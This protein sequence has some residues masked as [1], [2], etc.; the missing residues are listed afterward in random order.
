MQQPEGSNSNG[1]LLV[2]L[3]GPILV[4]AVV[5]SVLISLAQTLTWVAIIQSSL[6]F[7]G[8]AVAC[9]DSASIGHDRFRRFVRTQLE[10][11]VWDDVLHK[12]FHPDFSWYN[13]FTKTF[14]GQAA[15]VYLFPSTPEQRR[16]LLQATL[17]IND[18]DQ[19]QQI[20]FAPGGYQK[21]LLPDSFLQWLEGGEKKHNTG[22]MEREG[23]IKSK[24]ECANIIVV[25]TVLEG[26]TMSSSTSESVSELDTSDGTAHPKNPSPL[27]TEKLVRENGGTN[28]NSSE[29]STQHQQRQR[30]PKDASAYI[31][32]SIAETMQSVI[33]EAVS[34]QIRKLLVYT[35]N[36]KQTAALGV[37]AAVSLAMQLRWSKRS[38]T[39]ALGFLEASSI[40]GLSAVT[41]G[42]GSMFLAKGAFA[43]G[44]FQL[45]ERNLV[46]YISTILN[47]RNN[48][49]EVSGSSTDVG[50]ESNTSKSRRDWRK[51]YYAA[52]VVMLLIGLKK[53]KQARQQQVR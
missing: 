46:S 2:L 32:P 52:A 3:R 4:A 50:S 23:S 10:G 16:H 13:F 28:K 41:A 21:M 18:E 40:S 5:T 7:V 47:W 48:M 53:R 27:P 19:A 45:N 8:C 38:R 34:N 31:I 6:L 42:A 29:K 14:V 22:V 35:P 43:L 39:M 49:K 33:V 51:L 20:L 44:N 25:E 15:W 1:D 24:D 26:D 17:N 37:A 30:Q 12:F 36:Q 11:I 9:Y